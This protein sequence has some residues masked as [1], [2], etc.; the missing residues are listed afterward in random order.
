MQDDSL[1]KYRQELEQLRAT[2]DRLKREILEEKMMNSL[3]ELAFELDDAR[4]TIFNLPDAMDDDGKD[5]NAR[6]K[7]LI[8]SILDKAYRHC[9]T[10]AILLQRMTGRTIFSLSNGYVGIRLETYYASK[11][12]EPFYL[13]INQ[14][15]RDAELRI[16]KHTIPHFIPLREL[17]K[18]FLNVDMDVSTNGL[19]CDTRHCPSYLTRLKQCLLHVLEDFVQAFVSRRE[20][21]IEIAQYLENT[22][23]IKVTCDDAAKSIVSIIAN[24]GNGLIRVSLRYEDLRSEFPTK[25]EVKQEIRQV[26]ADRRNLVIEEERLLDKEDSFYHLRLTPAFISTFGEA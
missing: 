12:R 10:D 17:E 1:S 23:A 14:E 4:L 21:I 26:S 9:V 5:E 18:K 7:E 2:R 24:L 11:F 15:T 13:L 25:V 3:T 6:K 22:P 20:Q 16:A 8:Q 19:P